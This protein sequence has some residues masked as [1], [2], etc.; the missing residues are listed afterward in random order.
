MLQFSII[1]PVYNRPQE[2]DE[3]LESLVLQTDKDFDVMV[4]EGKCEHSCKLVCDKYCDR[5]N[6][7]FYEDN[8]GRSERR[9]LGMQNQTLEKLI[10]LLRAIIYRNNY[11]KLQHI[12]FLLLWLLMLL[13]NLA[14]RAMQTYSFC[15]PQHLVGRM[16]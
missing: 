16:D 3:F 8:S 7:K 15:M 11:R 12:K 2:M 9:N 6:I 13:H 5:L 4:M 1:V 14:C 10:H